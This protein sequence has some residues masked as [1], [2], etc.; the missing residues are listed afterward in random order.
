MFKKNACSGIGWAAAISWGIALGVP[1]AARGEPGPI[2]AS[3][4]DAADIDVSELTISKIQNAYRHNR[5]TAEALTQAY[6]CRIEHYEPA[7]NAFTAMNPNALEEAREIDRRRRNGEV[8]GPLAG[9][10]VVIKES[11][12]HVGLPSTAGW[13][14][15]SSQVA[16]GVDLFPSR[17]AVVVDRLIAAGAIIL[18]KTNIPAFSDNGTRANSSWAGPTY[19]AVNRSLAP[20][21]SSSGTATAVAANLAV[22]GLAEE[23]GGSI[24]NPAAAQSLVGVKPTFALVPTTGVVPLAGSTRD[25]VGPIARTVFDAALMMDVL[26]GYS[27]DD[28]KTSASVGKLP[29]SGYTGRLKKYALHGKRIGLYGL[30]W[31]LNELSAETQDLYARA[32][33]ELEDQ[34]A[35]VVEDPFAGSGFAELALPGEPYDMRG[36]ESLAYDFQR[37]LG[38]L[39]FGGE[40]VGS[41]DGLT[42]IT[43]ISPFQ[44]DGGPLFWYV[45]KL[46]TLA[47]S[48]SHPEDLPD[49]SDFW[50]LRSRYLCIFN[51]VMAENDLD[52]LAFPQTYETVPAL[53]GTDTYPST[54]ESALNIAAL[55]GVTVPAGQYSDGAPFSLIFVG[56]RWSEPRLLGFAY[57]YEQATRH[58][59]E[60]DLSSE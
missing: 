21:A 19:N 23:T 17:N 56:P 50:D 27:P 6:L 25:V 10:P 46:P 52:A 60:P 41:I 8:L 35:T 47:S 7:Y 11:M 32:I 9:I 16:G 59:I 38:G 24:Q 18:G 45:D 4:I 49:L 42:A 30:G 5:Y 43:G 22:L 20:G 55:P 1:G 28:P 26:A 31:R 44:P 14:P 39:T 33:E 12:D 40:E 54:T 48:L 2:D 36:T 15:L 29:P 51:S 13:A 57:D 3:D 53:S 37:Y 34:G 58:R